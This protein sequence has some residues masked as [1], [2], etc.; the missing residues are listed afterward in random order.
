MNSIKARAAAIAVVPT[1]ALLAVATAFVFLCFLSFQSQSDL[2]S[3]T[4]LAVRAGELVHRLQVE[5]GR[6]V[7]Y[8]AERGQN[9]HDLGAPYSATDASWRTLQVEL[10][11]QEAAAYDS[12]AWDKLQD[13]H[14]DLENIADLRVAVSE[15]KLTVAEAFARYTA[16]IEDGLTIINDTARAG[17][18]RR[19]VGNA[20]AVYADLANGKEFAG[21]E[22]AMGA[23]ALASPTLQLRDI[24]PM[25][26]WRG[27]QHGA[28]VGVERNATPA[29]AAQWHAVIEDEASL[30][31]ERL[32]D[33]AFQE[34]GATP[35]ITPTQWFATTTARIEAIHTVELAAAKQAVASV[36]AAKTAALWAL[37]IAVGTAVLAVAA[38]V[39]VGLTVVRSI[40]RPLERLTA[41]TRALA[42]GDLDLHIDTTRGP[43]EIR[44]IGE[45]LSV[46]REAIVANQAL[47]RE[48]ASSSR[49]ASLGAMVAGIA[50]E[51]N[52]PIGN[53]VMVSST[54]GE[55]L[56]QF[57]GEIKSGSLRRSSIDR[58][59][60]EAREGTTMLEANL[61]RASEQIRSFKQAAV[62][63][64]SDGR[65]SFKLGATISDAVRSCT[66]IT[67][68]AGI[69]VETAFDPTIEMDSYPGALSQVIVNLIENAAKH[70]LPNADTK[71]IEIRTQ[72]LPG[73]EALIEF[74]DTGVGVP[75][76]LASKVFG[77]FFTTQA[78]NGGS[79][80]GLHIVQSIVNGQ[81]GGQI[82]L[83]SGEGRGARFLIRIPLSPDARRSK[84][85]NV[86]LQA[87]AA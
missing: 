76:E 81:L 77:A 21:R 75:A 57:E 64:A 33:R 69:V 85:S 83:D 56:R 47:S 61:R 55:T 41:N 29:I 67:R 44:A 18:G 1:A 60:A 58:F 17:A 30:A 54:F 14:R 5:R 15:R 86:A 10:G 8:L 39:L 78:A 36:Q 22:R 34:L 7:W 32:R 16:W 50:H 28:F 24:A 87:E 3:E 26:E 13:L 72:A 20:L 79:G 63:Q 73:N 66:P 23:V 12:S 82:E 45:A 31:Y 11:D 43:R 40:T 46:F 25:F 48:L 53:A 49:A 35:S 51:I 6:S 9:A 42:A 65:R 71:R 2:G 62:D 68:P 38:A 52:T 19:S 37:I 84:G 80:L 59:L 4:S 27:A 70:G 74:S